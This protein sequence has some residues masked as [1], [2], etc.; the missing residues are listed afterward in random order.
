VAD[1]GIV[2]GAKSY[3]GKEYN[4]CLVSRVNTGVSRYSQGRVV[5]LLFSGGDDREDRV[6]ESETM[7]KIAI[8]RGVA[9]NAILLEKQSTSTYENLVNSQKIMKE[10]G[11]EKAIIIS[12][13]FH[14]ARARL[15]GRTL[16]IQAEYMASA[17][18]PCWNRWTYFS[19][20]FLKEPIT[21][22]YYVVTGKISLLSF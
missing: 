1:V 7:K 14:M 12:E 2:L 16:G 19:R 9:E 20:Y 22:M 13:P 15:I 4:P 8:E 6:N 18:S 5:Y 21:I 10:R 17:D 3:K 11:L